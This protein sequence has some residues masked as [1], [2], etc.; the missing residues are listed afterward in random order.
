MPSQ[1]RCKYWFKAALS[2][3]STAAHGHYIGPKGATPL[4]IGR[5]RPQMRQL[6]P[7]ATWTAFRRGVAW[8]ELAG[9]SVAEVAGEI[10]LLLAVGKEFG[11]DKTGEKQIARPQSAMG[12]G[13]TI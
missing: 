11:G 13:M 12:F 6:K 2:S 7:A 5:E 1:G 10:D 8:V 9:V 3:N 4:N